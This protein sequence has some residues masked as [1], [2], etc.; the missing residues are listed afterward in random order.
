MERER[1]WIVPGWPWA[2]ILETG[3]PL[4]HCLCNPKQQVISWL[5]GTL[6]TE[7]GKEGGRAGT[8]ICDFKPVQPIN[9]LGLDWIPSQSPRPLGA[10]CPCLLPWEWR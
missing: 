10:F 7:E 6:C 8:Q 3:T 4:L 1:Q 9:H 5:T 2:G